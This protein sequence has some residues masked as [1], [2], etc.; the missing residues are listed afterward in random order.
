MNTFYLL[1]CARGKRATRAP[2]ECLYQ[3]DLF[4]KALGVAQESGSP[5]FILS[6]LHGLLDPDEVIAP[7]DVSL[8]EMDRQARARW[9]AY[10]WEQLRGYLS[11]G[12]RVVMYAGQDYR[13]PLLPYLQGA[14]VQVDVPLQGLDIGYQKQALAGQLARSRMMERAAEQ[15][16]LFGGGDE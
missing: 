13:A 14:G 16:S 9:A 11:P 12:D 1:S 8:Q 7:Y 15:L 6:A 10:V 4:K 5:Y 3:S 2:A